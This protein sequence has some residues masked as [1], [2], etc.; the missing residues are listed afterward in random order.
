MNPDE[1]G[2][3]PAIETVLAGLLAF[4]N[5]SQQHIYYLLMMNSTG[6]LLPKASNDVACNWDR[7]WCRTNLRS[8]AFIRD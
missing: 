7:V 5:S 8:S 6:V 4:R 3:P 2:F 1:R